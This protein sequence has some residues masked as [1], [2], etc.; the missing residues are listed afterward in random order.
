M[1]TQEEAVA[2]ALAKY[3]DA[4]N[5]S[6][7]EVV[8]KLYAPD[9]VFMPQNFPSSV[10]A[11]AVRFAAITLTVKFEIAEIRQIASD[12][13]IART[14]SAGTVKV[15]ATGKGGPIPRFRDAVEQLEAGFDELVITD[16]RGF[17][18]SGD[19]DKLKI[20]YPS[21]ILT[22]PGTAT[23]SSRVDTVDNRDVSEKK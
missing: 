1:N 20:V 10:G 12:W 18:E 2:A 3:Q 23:P 14:N 19:L 13:A 7:T 16:G 11:D 22:M 17:R 6:S 5:G 9:G 21:D 8:M 15:N 4:L